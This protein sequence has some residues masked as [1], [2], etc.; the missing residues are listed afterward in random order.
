MKIHAVMLGCLCKALL[1]DICK[2]EK[3][4]LRAVIKY[5]CMKGMPPNEIHED[6]VETLGRESPSYGTVKKWAA[7]FKREGKREW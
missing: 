3:L 1:R 4:V 2:M 7:A 5:F 6:F